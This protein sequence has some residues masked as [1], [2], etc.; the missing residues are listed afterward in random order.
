[1][2]LLATTG[3]KINGGEY[4]YCA[5]ITNTTKFGWFRYKG[6]DYVNGTKI[7][8]NGNCYI[9]GKSM[10]LCNQIVTFRY[11]QNRNQY[12]DYHGVL[13]SC[14]EGEF[15]NSIVYIITNEHVIPEK[16][17][18]ELFWTDDMVAKTIWYIAIMIGAVIF[19]DCI[20]IWIFATI[21][22]YNSVIKKNK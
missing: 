11:H 1:M 10:N 5:Y 22:W 9:N 21:W 16:Q 3:P 7:M 15:E 19:K 18:K 17:K 8:Y 14:P 13:Y 6:K 12:F 20:A 2:E 4:M